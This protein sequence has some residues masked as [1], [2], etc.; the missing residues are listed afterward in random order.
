MAEQR[1]IVILGASF[2]GLST[3]HYILKHTLPA[4]KVKKDAEY[5]VY[6]INPSADF[7]FR[8]AS[9]RVAASTDRLPLS[10]VLYQLSDAFKPY[11]SED[12]TFIQATA[13]GLNTTG[14]TVS[15]TRTGSETNEELLYHAL[16]IATGSRTHDKAYSMH[17]DTPTLLSAIEK[18]N[19]ELKTAKDIII[20]GGGPTSVESAGEMGELLNGKPG[21]FSTPKRK[22]NITLITASDQLLPALAPHIGKKAEGRLKRLGVDVL[23]N[24]RVVDAAKGSDD[25]FTVTLSKSEKLEVDLYIPAQGVVPNSSFLPKNLLNS[26]G[27]VTTNAETLRVDEAGPRVYAIGDIADYSR[28]TILDI[29]DSLP[30][31]V[32]NL[33]RDLLS[34]NPSTPDSKPKGKDRIYKVNFKITQAVPIGSAGGVGALAGWSLPSLLIWWV[35]ARDMLTWMA[36]SYFIKGEHASVKNEAKLTKEEE[37][38]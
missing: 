2:A 3:V 33:K 14:R 11:S 19:A 38:D 24:T 16:I 13:T 25:R 5:H 22:V 6:I 32:V 1:N 4:L 34:Y 18:R 31:L 36:T 37:V 27:Y 7:Y 10:K 20:S 28:N 30:V 15:F 17:I 21:W 23:Y 35:K 12:L 8:C 9:S 29:Y 26:S